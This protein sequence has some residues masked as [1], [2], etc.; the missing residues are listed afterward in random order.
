MF[1]H[2]VVLLVP[3]HRFACQNLQMLYQ[4]LNNVLGSHETRTGFLGNCAKDIDIMPKQQYFNGILHHLYVVSAGNI[5]L[6]LQIL[7]FLNS[8]TKNEEILNLFKILDNTH[9]VCKPAFDW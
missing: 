1:P 4:F 6:L 3:T 7:Y 9:F 5:L 8:E 2:R